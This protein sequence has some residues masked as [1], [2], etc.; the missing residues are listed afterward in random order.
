MD[1]AFVLI[2]QLHD[3]AERQEPYNRTGH[4]VTHME[5]FGSGDPGIFLEGFDGQA[6]PA[7]FFIQAFDVDVDLFAYFVQVSRLH[8][9]VTGGTA[10]NSA[11][12]SF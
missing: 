1:H 4:D 6:D 10:W 12:E 7:F 5:F 9:A 2:V 8:A 3:G 11:S